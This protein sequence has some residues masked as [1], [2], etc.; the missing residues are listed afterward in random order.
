MDLLLDTCTFLWIISGSSSLSK[1][2]RLLYID[3]N[4]AVY[5]SAASAWEIGVKYAIHKLPLPLPPDEYIPEQR[6]KHR[7]TSLPVEESAV[8]YLPK[9]PDI[10]ADPFDRML[11]CQA[12]WHNLVIVTP[13]PLIKQYPVKTVW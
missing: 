8:L 13:D 12:L 2:V 9:L 3:P 10:H 1:K 6:A 11:V 4:N 5:L 7:V